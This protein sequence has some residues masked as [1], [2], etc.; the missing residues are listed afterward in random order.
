MSPETI[1]HKPVSNASMPETRTVNTGETLMSQLSTNM[2]VLRLS[3]DFTPEEVDTL[4]T[5]F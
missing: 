4:S 1:G 3:P 2:L 5:L